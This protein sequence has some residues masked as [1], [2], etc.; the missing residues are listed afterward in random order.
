[1]KH[2]KSFLSVYESFEKQGEKQAII[3]VRQDD[4]LFV[5]FSQFSNQI[6]KAAAGLKKAGIK[7]GDRVLIQ[8]DNCPAW[9]MMVFAVILAGGVVVPLD[10]QLDSHLTA[11]V[12]KDCDVKLAFLMAKKETYLRQT[13]PEI[14][15]PIYHLDGEMGS[16]QYWEILLSD[17]PITFSEPDLESIAVQ[18]YTSG[19]TGM[20]KGVPLTHYNILFELNTFIDLQ[21]QKPTDRVL[22]PLPFHHVYPFVGCLLAVLSLGLPIILPSALT[23][24]QL[25]R[26]MQ[27]GDAT[28]IIAV[29]GLLRA[30]YQG[31][32]GKAQGAG[33]LSSAVFNL[34]FGLNKFLIRSF[35][36]NLG[37]VL[38][39]SLHKK[40][41]PKLRLLFS[42]GAA[43][44]ADIAIGLE[45]LGWEVCTGYGLTETSPLLTLNLRPKCNLHS[46]GHVLDGTEIK[47]DPTSYSGEPVEGYLTGEVLAKG[48]NVFGGYH[49]LPEVNKRVF[50]EDGWFRTGDLGY[51]D[52]NG[53]LFLKGRISSMIVTEEGKNIDPEALEEVFLQQPAISEVAVLERKG[54]LVAIIIPNLKTLHDQGKEEISKAIGL[55][56]MKASEDLPTYKRLV[57]YVITT[58]PIP[59]TRLNKIKRHELLK[60]YEK[61]KASEEQG[62]QTFGRPIAIEE[63]SE[64][65]RDLLDQ[66]GAKVIWDWLCR[67]YS[68]YALTPD[69]NM[70]FDLGIDSI[71]WLNLSLEIRQQAGLELTEEIMARIVRVRDLLKEVSTMKKISALSPQFN[72]FDNPE[73]ALTDEQKIWLKSLNPFQKVASSFFYSLNRA[74]IRLFFPVKAEGQNRI[75][76]GMQC[77]F[78]P[79]HISELD[80]FLIASTL[81]NE[82]LQSVQWAGWVGATHQNPFRRFVSRIIGIVPIDPQHALMSNL[83]YGAAAIKRG[84]QLFWFPEGMISLDGKLGDFRPGVGILSREFNIPI[85]PIL[86][87]GTDHAFPRGSKWVKRVPLTVVF[88]EPVLPAIL[89][90]EGVGETPAEK[91]VDGLKQRLIRIQSE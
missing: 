8:G 14:T 57:D 25:V 41:G 20:P 77:I 85:V 78:A 11:Y 83:T 47:I 35:D 6:K 73:A 37:R 60:L 48:K 44:P 15:I 26:A 50:T 90:S 58:E 5:T 1:M 49:N 42:G 54:K 62:H 91:I 46:A 82:F 70:Q 38:L 81:K 52:K 30:L 24:P 27:I 88:G 51:F 63:M 31:I 12:I 17:E 16:S 22:N 19:T 53:F 71:E 68:D 36:L 29:P 76:S 32:I 72:P 45:G 18:F 87:K 66:Q 9:M 28:V 55:A 59:R 21:I 65:D 64:A 33:G 69:S 43:L 7:P 67:K 80:S 40:I 75:P 79:N 74:F 23:G 56:I 84:K 13:H 10:A 4:A 61:Q 89:E 34:L 39:F 2:Y 3:Q 86:V